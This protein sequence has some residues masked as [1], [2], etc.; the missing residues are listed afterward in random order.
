M[1]VLALKQV[2][3]YMNELVVWQEA[4]PRVAEE[5]GPDTRVVVAHSLGS[6]VAYE[7]LCEHPEWPVTDLVTV[8]SPL[9]MSLIFN[10]LSL[11]PHSL[12]RYLTARKTGRA[13]A[14]G[15]T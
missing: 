8:G 14:E 2:R 10:R 1:M 5:I 6:V 12:L 9:G 11:K 4:R 3:R 15:L 7:A 13:V